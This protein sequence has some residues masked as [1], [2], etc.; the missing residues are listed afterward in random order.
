MSNKLSRDSVET[1][2]LTERLAH[3]EDP[4]PQQIEIHPTDVCN[5]RCVYCFHDG[6]GFDPTRKDLLS[7]DEY[8]AL[9]SQ[10]RALNIVNLLVSGGGE[11]LLDQRAPNILRAARSND[12]EVRL[13]TNGTSLSDTVSEEL[14]AIKAVRFS[15]DAVNPA[16][17]AKIRGASPDTHT[18]VMQNISRL[19]EL[20]HSRSS[21]LRVGVALLL[22]EYNYGEA[23]DF[24]TLML[25]LGVDSVTVRH[26]VYAR[27]AVPQARFEQLRER[28]LARSDPRITV[29]AA[30][31]PEIIAGTI[32]YTPF[33][34]VSVNPYGDVYSCCLSAQPKSEVGY[35]LGNLHG[36]RFG[37]VWQESAG[38]RLKMRTTG[39]GCK[40][41]T[42]AD[43]ESNKS[44][45]AA[46]DA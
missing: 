3:G 44:M 14:L 43:Y 18:R 19:L 26:D 35:L 46:Q 8:T 36:K 1:L 25:G 6:T 39:V 33:F 34:E 30:P 4:F 9:F 12:L 13:I 21:A 20:K 29:R 23:E 41:C 24:C 27:N 22:T 2:V 5:Q 32:C 28:L 37:D 11:P 7:L 42:P 16:T 15:V 17:Y 31:K 45:A 10:M 38:I 40:I